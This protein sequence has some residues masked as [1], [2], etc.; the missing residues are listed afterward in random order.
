MLPVPAAK[1]W[2]VPAIPTIGDLSDWLGVLPGELDWFAD[3]AALTRGGKL[4]HYHYRVLTKS[5]GSLRLIEAPKPYL[6]G[7]QQQIL[8]KILDRIPPHT[9]SQGFVKGRSVKTFVT[10]HVEK[11]VVLKMDLQDFFPSIIGAR[12]QTV[13][14]T[15]GYPES[16]ADLL[17]GICSNA[18]PRGVWKSLNASADVND[19]FEARSLYA[20]PHLPQGAPTSPALANICFYRADCRLA[21]LAKAAGASYSRYADD[22]AFSGGDEF[23]RTVERFAA[24]VAAILTEEGFVVHH[25][26]TRVMRAGVR[27]RLTGIVLNHHANIPR[28]DFD[29]LK[30][31]LTNC[32]RHGFDSQNREGHIDFRSHLEGRVAWVESVNPARGMRLRGLLDVVKWES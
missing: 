21:G 31:T 13:F 30:A 26:K 9:A 15:M 5:S 29:R 27:Q 25:R 16:V 17:G 11:Q 32:V 4:A 6:K 24:H 14:R 22:L 1:D 2:K 10:P 7:L 8:A 28:E 12:I 20:H 3:L 19:L 18:T 23:A